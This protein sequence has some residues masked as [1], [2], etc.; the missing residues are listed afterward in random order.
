MG[1]ALLAALLGL[2]VVAL[3][4][5][6]AY[7]G[8][9]AAAPVLAFVGVVVVLVVLVVLVFVGTIL[10]SFVRTLRPGHVAEYEQFM[11]NS[12]GQDVQLPMTPTATTPPGR[13]AQ[14]E[15]P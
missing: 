4:V 11:R 10:Y 5:A 7:G 3:C 9:V 14:K 13:Q 8:R 1:I 6:Y 2:A 12:R 15:Q